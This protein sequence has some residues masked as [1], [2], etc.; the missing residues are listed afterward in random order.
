MQSERPSSE[1]D[2]LTS[3]QRAWH[4]AITALALVLAAFHVY[5]AYAGPFYAIA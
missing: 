3:V 5:T 1:R 2:R 4:G